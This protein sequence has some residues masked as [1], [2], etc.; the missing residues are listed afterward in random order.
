MKQKYSIIFLAVLSAVVSCVQVDEAALGEQ[1]EQREM[2]TM[3]VSATLEKGA[4]TKTALEGSLSDAVMH[5]LWEPSDKIG[6]VAVRPAMGTAEQVVGF[7][8]DITENAE[9]A[10]FEGTIAFASEYHAFYPYSST[11]KDSCGVFIF[12]LPQEQKYVANSFDPVAAPMVA[13]APYGESLDFKHLC[14]F[15]AIQIKGE[16]TVKSITFIGK[17]QSGA[18]MPV[19]GKF[20]A[21][22]YYGDEPSIVSK[23]NL[24]S[25]TMT[26]ATPVALSPDT[27][28]P[29]YFV[30]PPATYSSFFVMIQTADGKV[31]LREGT[32][33]L[34]VSR[35]HMKPTAALK[36]AESIYIDLSEVGW[37]NCYIVP[38]AGLYSFDA[39]VIGNGEYGLVPEVSF[40]TD[41]VNIDPK[42][43]ELLWEDR[44]SMISGLELKDG[45]VR[46]FSTGVEGN[47]LV[48][49]KDASGKI[50]WSW[51]IWVTDQ[52]Q[53]QVYSSNFGTFTMLD[54]NNGAIRADRGEGEEW[55]E[56]Q[57]VQ[58]QWGRKDP[59]THFKD[60]RGTVNDRNLFSTNQSKVQISESI[61]YPTVF[62]GAG[63]SEWEST[64]NNSLW[65]S[66]Q[67]TI[68]DPCPVGYRM[69]TMEVW[70]GFTTDGEDKYGSSD[71]YM[72]YGG[73]DNG[74]YFYYDGGNITYYPATNLIHDGG[75][76]E[77]WENYA[78]RMW[79]ATYNSQSHARKFYFHYNSDSDSHISFSENDHK[80]YGYAVRCMKDEGHVDTSYP[81][82]AIRS[83]VDVTS[84]SATV[85]ADVFNEGIS[86]VTERGIVWGL[87]ENLTVD[88]GTKVVADAAGGGEYRTTL[89]GLQNATVYYVRPYAINSKGLSY[90]KVSSFRTT[91][92]GEANNLSVYGTSNC[93]VVDPAYCKH[94]INGSVKGHTYESIGSVASVEVLWETNGYGMKT[95]PG[96]VIFDVT[97]K[98]GN[99]YFYTNGVEG[100]ALVASKDAM[101]T[102]LWSWHIWVTDTPQENLYNGYYWVLDRNLGAVSAEEGTG[103]QWKLSCGLPYQRGRKD[104][105]VSG[106]FTETYAY[107]S[108]EDAIA[109]PLVRDNGWNYDND[110]WSSTEKAVYD[111][112]PVGYR[113]AVNSVWDNTSMTATDN[114]H[115]V[116][117]YFDTNPSTRYW[118]PFQAYHQT[119]NIEYYSSGR[120]LTP[121]SGYYWDNDSKW[122]SGESYAQVRCMKDEGYIDMS[123]PIVKMTVPTDITSDG[124][125]I[126]AEITNTGIA[127]ITSR[128]FIWGT[129]EDLTPENG[130]K[131]ECGAGAGKFSK[132]LDGLSHSTRYY[133]MAYATNE[134]GTSYSDVMS[135]FTPY[136][137]SAVNLSKDGTANCYIVPVAYSEYAFNASVRGN[138]NESVGNIAKAEVLWES[139]NDRNPINVGDVIAS[140]SF[141]GNMV[142]FF[143][144]TEPVAGNAVIA[145]KDALGTILWSWHIW[146]TDYDPVATQ[147][148]Y[149]S[150]AVMMDRNLGAL[151]MT[152]G[153]VG[154][155]G[156]FYQWGR[157]DP[158]AG[159]GVTWNSG[160]HAF[161]APSDAIRYE[162]YN[163]STDTMENA[164]KNP[165][166]VYDDA[167]W[168]EATDLWGY[169]K[170]KYDPCPVGWRVS[171]RAAWEGLNM[172][173]NS[174]DYLMTDAPYSTSATYFPTAGYTDG[175]DY[176]HHIYHGAYFW[177]TERGGFIDM[178]WDRNPYMPSRDVDYLHSV[179]CMKDDP[180]RNGDNEDYTEGDDYE[181]ND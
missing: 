175:S 81:S 71:E 141:D 57:G 167:R 20:E 96:T 115:G 9:V 137:G 173:Y 133:A 116:Y 158:F 160:E 151:N 19:S 15:L 16:E 39:T 88:S 111:P 100:N 11:L 14:G 10:D 7:V 105:F 110:T 125:T 170:T 25:V 35:S 68:Y 61:E 44:E 18:M 120:L 73:Y 145:V 66:G 62:E 114:G 41:N 49:V 82:V 159:S 50:L 4:D 129:S 13:K 56:A 146:V 138:S 79:T 23:S 143:L 113:V 140:V 168:S 3:S 102:I 58:Y 169:K 70:R 64:G 177:V 46:F 98:D 84:E 77:R 181:W 108:M 123:Y 87:S 121:T 29:F 34:T 99:I 101:G 152:P 94:Y 103:E 51:H 60:P 131:V 72:N 21:N 106:T 37:S 52:P 75:G 69:P 80:T 139:R 12:N 112:C 153:D 76:Y 54:R 104:P 78:C 6:L 8:T 147:Q 24:R 36:Y 119:D 165:T 43:V 178:W 89:T 85:V 45:E 86:E 91:Y 31:M 97:L 127:A 180:D 48:A 42:T 5:T 155:H 55:H 164:V 134:R 118:Y 156:L 161:T 171:D 136:E 174:Q 92:A 128:G 53:D 150:G 144:P 157:K 107:Y 32:N 22:M 27:A 95:D 90:G 126:N 109:H 65:S 179:R 148:T 33:P 93:Y 132:K 1:Q 154:S 166:V 176:I 74:W 17:D 30:L 38:Q 2:I 47:A 26:C 117:F 149:I 59:F 163:S 67:K 172:T 122:N 83:V 130:T 162:Y 124:A 142:H 63:Y 40:H 135:F 28:T